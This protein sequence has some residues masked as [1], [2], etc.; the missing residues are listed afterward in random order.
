LKNGCRTLPSADFARYSISAS[1]SGSTQPGEHLDLSVGEVNVDAVAIELDL[2]DPP[3]AARSFLDRGCQRRLNE[4]GEGRLD[5]DRH[6]F[7]ALERHGLHQAHRK[8]Q[9]HVA[10]SVEPIAEVLKE[11]WHVAHLQI[12][13]MTHFLGDVCRDVLRP[14]FGGVET[15][16]P[17]RGF[18][19]PL[20][21][22]H[23]DRFEI[24]ALNVAR[25]LRPKSSRT[26]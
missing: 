3:I 14:T 12:A 21:H 20:E 15:Y 2:V 1:R 17:D 24:G 22:V 25:P 4:T 19:L 13:P 26:I 5:A 10:I 6:G 7:L 11:E 9:L 23:D 16:N 18:V 8:R